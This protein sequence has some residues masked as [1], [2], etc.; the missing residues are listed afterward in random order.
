M[1]SQTL[2]PHLPG[3]VLEHAWWKDGCAE[4]Q[5]ASHL[6]SGLPSWG[7]TGRA[8]PP[9][10]TSFSRQLPSCLLLLKKTHF[11]A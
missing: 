1:A 2:C 9:T 10:D 5:Q 8:V 4:I 3:R 6:A 11:K 7:A